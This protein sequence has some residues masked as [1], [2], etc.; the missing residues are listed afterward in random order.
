MYSLVFFT[1]G[2]KRHHLDLEGKLWY[3]KNQ[4]NV[5]EEVT[6]LREHLLKV[7]IPSDPTRT[8]RFDQ[9]CP[10]YFPGSGGAGGGAKQGDQFRRQERKTKRGHAI[11][12]KKRNNREY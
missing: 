8:L 9:I 12:M 4:F 11:T 2:G 3:K 7:P 6:S 5:P 1:S 10:G